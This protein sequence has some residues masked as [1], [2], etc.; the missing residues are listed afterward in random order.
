MK[1]IHIVNKIKTRWFQPHVEKAMRVMPVTVLTGP[2]QTGKTTLAKEVEPSAAYHTLDDLGILNQA[3][4]DP[5]SLTLEQPVIIDEVQRAP[6]LVL[7]VKHAVDLHRRAG[8]FL[9]TGSANLLLMKSIADSL[10]GR[11]IYLQLPPFCPTEW[12]GREGNLHPLDRL[13]DADFELREWPVG[14]GNWPLWLLRGGFPPALEIANESDRNLWMG[15]YVQTYLER[16][17]RQLSEVS[18]LPDF[19]RLM[20]MAAQ[21]TGRLLNQAELARDASL[22]Q[23]TTHRYLNLLEAGCIMTR[24]RPFTSNPTTALIKTPRL[25]WRDCGLASWLAGIRSSEAA[26]ARMDAGFWLEQ[27]L[28][29][30]LQTWQAL[31]PQSRCLHF[32]RDR[33]GR[34]VDFI[35]EKEGRFVALEIKTSKQVNPSDASGIKALRETMKNKKA[36]V[37]GAVLYGGNEPRHLSHDDLALPWGWMVPMNS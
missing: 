37:R 13:F 32:W 36:L 1:S 14:Q 20:V 26:T 12:L 16:D 9:L 10:A 8:A 28:F 7:A 35:L 19:Q 25:Y 21:R 29:Q 24:L 23:P 5:A 27:T 34:E 31:D 2:R 22:S 11:A 30:T 6:R 3:L 17:L 18:S 4:Q 15:A 33:S